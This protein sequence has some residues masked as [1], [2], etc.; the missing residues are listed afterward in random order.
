MTSA[1]LAL[2][3]RAK[4]LDEACLWR[5]YSWLHL[6]LLP[7]QFMF[8]LPK[9]ALARSDV[10]YSRKLDIE[11]PFGFLTFLYNV[12]WLYISYNHIADSCCVACD[13][14]LDDRATG[15]TTTLW[16]GGMVCCALL[17][18]RVHVPGQIYGLRF[19]IGPIY[20]VGFTLATYLSFGRTLC[21]K[22]P[23]GTVH[24]QISRSRGSSGRRRLNVKGN[25][26]LG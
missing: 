21:N 24:P 16:R 22:L 7:V 20:W 3:F 23:S 25:A 10:L 12:P 17:V 19:Y 14:L 26:S 6:G 5:T 9:L 1:V 11:T 18:L 13:L 15:E 8:P 4:G 2:G